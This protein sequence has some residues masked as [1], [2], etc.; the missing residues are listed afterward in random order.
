MNWLTRDIVLIDSYLVQW[1]GVLPA[2]HCPKIFQEAGP[3]FPPNSLTYSNS[4]PWQAAVQ[5]ENDSEVVNAKWRKPILQSDSYRTPGAIEAY[6]FGIIVRSVEDPANYSCSV[7]T[8]TGSNSESS[9]IGFW[10]FIP[11]L[12]AKTTWTFK[13]ITLHFQ[14]TM[15]FAVIYDKI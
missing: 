7:V 8:W 14:Y 9:S 5:N 12:L 13:W 15:Q 10:S 1:K 6:N 3:M 11:E 2:W 4:Q